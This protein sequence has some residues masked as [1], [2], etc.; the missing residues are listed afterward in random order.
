VLPVEIFAHR[1]DAAVA[2]F[3]QEVV[4]LALGAADLEVAARRG[5]DPV[6]VEDA[7]RSGALAASAGIGGLAP[8][9]MNR[10]ARSVGLASAGAPASPWAAPVFATRSPRA[11]RI[12]P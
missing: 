5:L 11:A 12:D 6:A 8:P 1:A 7:G 3:E 4:L 2:K 10:L 9:V